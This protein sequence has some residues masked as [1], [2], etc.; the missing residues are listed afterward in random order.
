MEK[1]RAIFLIEDYFNFGNKIYF[2]YRMIKR[3][4]GQCMVPP[5]QNGL[6]DHNFLEVVLTEIFF[7]DIIRHKL[8]AAAEVSFDMH[9]CYDRLVHK[10]GIMSWQAFG[11]PL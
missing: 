7:N 11:V 9:T 8:W 2:G 1:K 10:Y 4:T 6:Q 3:S 5:E